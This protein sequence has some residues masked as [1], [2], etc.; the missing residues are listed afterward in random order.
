MDR[1][2]ARGV[3]V[4][5]QHAQLELS[6]SVIIFLGIQRVLILVV[7]VIVIVVGVALPRF[8][9]LRGRTLRL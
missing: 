2:I 6:G 8:A 5:V 9:S 3:L 1:V 4:L 7:I